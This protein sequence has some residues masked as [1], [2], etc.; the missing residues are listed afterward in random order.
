MADIREKVGQ[1]I[2]ELRREKGISQEKLALLIGI[3]RTY[4]ASVEGGHRNISIIN[5]SKIWEGL[6]INAKDFF[7]TSIFRG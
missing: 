4:I 3:D 1:R 2:R 7:D 6:G 5:L